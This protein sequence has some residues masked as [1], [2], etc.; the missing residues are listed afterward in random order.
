MSLRRAPDATS[1]QPWQPADH[2]APDTRVDHVVTKVVSYLRAGVPGYAIADVNDD[3]DG[4]RRIQIILDSWR[5]DRDERVAADEDGRVR[6]QPLGLILGS[7]RDPVDGFIR[8]ACF[9]PATGREVG[10]RG[11]PAGPA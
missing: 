7:S 6:L 10:R 1:G 4:R 2:A 8:L 11:D 5:P 3:E 9:D